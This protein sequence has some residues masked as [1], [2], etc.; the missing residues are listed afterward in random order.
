[1]DPDERASQLREEIAKLDHAY[2]VLDEPLTDDYSYDMLLD[3]LREI[4][5]ENPELVTPDSPTQRVGGAPLDKFEQ[6]EHRERMLSLAN[7]R[8]AEELRAWEQRIENLLKRLDIS[9]GELSWVTEPKIDGLAISLT[10]EDGIFVRGTTRG[11]GT[12]G[13]VVTAN[14]KT[15]KSIPL[16]IPDAPPVIEVRGEIYFPRSGFERLNEQ[17]AEAGEST[18]ANPRNAAAGTLRQLDPGLTASRPLQIWAYAIGYREGVEHATHSDELDWLRE[19]GFRVQEDIASHSTIDEVVERCEWWEGRRD[20]IDFEIDGVVVK[21][22]DRALWR[23]LG[24][25]GREPRWAI[26]WKFPPTT[27][28]TRLNKIVWNVGR[29]GHMVPFA[30]LEPVHVGGVTVSTATLHNEEDLLKKDAREGDEVIVT[31]AG[32][33]IPRVVGPVMQSR[34]G[35]RLRKPKPPA[36]CPMCETPTVKPED[37]VWTICPNKTGCPGQTFQGLKHFVHR[38]AMDIEGFG[39]KNVIRFLDAGLI[40]DAADIY[41]LTSEKLQTLE[42][43]GEVSADN[44]IAAIEASKKQPF[45]RLLFG[46][47][48]QGVGGVNAE[49]LAAHFG[50]MEALMAATPEQIEEVDG[51]GPIMAESIAEQVADENF[52]ELVGRLKERGLRLELDESERRQEGGPLDGKTFVL[53]GTLPTLTRDEAGALIK[54]AGGKVTS[55]VSKKTD[56]VVAG[57]AAGSKL[58]KAERLGTEILDEDGLR[59]LL[60]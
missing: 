48:L 40:R 52:I 23:Q 45:P 37:G 9:P 58:E 15:I 17:R 1:M 5:S 55:S 16:K 49:Y 32:D 33:V 30:M 36:K 43:F 60:A 47:G 24:N 6:Y 19:R 28:T 21:V 41:D 50:S 38:G 35:K 29:T 44:L 10:Y 27:V 11:D 31:R 53:T 25:A 57:E 39:E 13:E 51:V 34:K 18:F 54:K 4:E 3:E 22:D 12:I 7:A 56:Y 59:E 20:E 8:N 14:L 2:Y 42:G 26:A 46:L